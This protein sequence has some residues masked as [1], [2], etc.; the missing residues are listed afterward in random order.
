MDT[1]TVLTYWDT[2]IW[3]SWWLPSLLFFS[4]SHKALTLEDMSL[5]LPTCHR[6]CVKPL[7]PTAQ[8]PHEAGVHSGWSCDPAGQTLLLQRCTPAPPWNEETNRTTALLTTF[9]WS[10]PRVRASR[11]D[12]VI[13]DLIQNI[14]DWN[15]RV[16]LASSWIIRCKVQ[17]I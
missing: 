14:L 5:A 6:Q 7:L 2:G 17:I 8:P 15:R 1:L 10:Q 16:H 12:H 13:W 4:D 9:K 3:T 11:T